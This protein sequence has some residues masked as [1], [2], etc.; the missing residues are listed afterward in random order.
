MIRKAY[1]RY[2]M[3]ND[4]GQRPSF[5]ELFYGFLGFCFG[6]LSLLFWQP[7]SFVLE[8]CRFCF[9]GLPL[10][11]WC[12]I[13]FCS[14]VFLSE[15]PDEVISFFMQEFTTFWLQRSEKGGIGTKI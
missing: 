15:N 8:A 9:G 7:V 10:M 1:A 2:L 13:D 14:A 5:F 12:A 11:F 3:K 6:S 4:S